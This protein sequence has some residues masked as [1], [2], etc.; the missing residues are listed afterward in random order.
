MYRVGSILNQDMENIEF[1]LKEQ[2]REQYCTETPLTHSLL[3]DTK[4]TLE[5]PE[6][7]LPT[8]TIASKYEASCWR[9]QQW[10]TLPPS[11]L[12]FCHLASSKG[13]D[14]RP[15]TVTSQPVN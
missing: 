7:F 8:D 15:S 4:R 1:G 9:Q 2:K 6:G 5:R 12:N 10:L 14:R 13:Q 11:H 3:S